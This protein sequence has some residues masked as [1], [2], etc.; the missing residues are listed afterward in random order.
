MPLNNLPNGHEPGWFGILCVVFISLWGGLVSYA[1]RVK[2]GMQFVL[3]HLL[4][5]CGASSF[6]GLLVGFV[7]FAFDVNFMLCLALAGISGHAGSRTLVYLNR[8]WG[9]KLK[10]ISDEINQ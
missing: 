8:I 10:S 1:N 3:W 9:N 2:N 4:V 6:A 5:D 7:A